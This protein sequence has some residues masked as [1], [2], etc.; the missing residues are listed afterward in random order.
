MGVSVRAEAGDWAQP[1]DGPRPV[2]A[3]RHDQHDEAALIDAAIAGDANAFA[4]LYDRHVARVYRHCYYRTGHRTDSEDLTQQTFLQAWLAIARY[5]RG[6]SPF[7]AWLLT[8]SQHLAMSHFR[9][10]RLTTTLEG[11]TP[12]TTTEEMDPE[13]ALSDLVTRDTVRTAILRLKPE[14]QQVIILRFIEGFTTEEI[15]A[16]IS[17]SEN[18]VRVLQHRALADLKRLLDTPMPDHYYDTEPNLMGRVR[19]ALTSAIGRIA[20]SSRSPS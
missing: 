8:I 4:M 10:A 2:A 5:R 1:D 12:T 17:K 20:P 3:S 7:I 16:A 15:A 9:K 19:G 13:A 18:N 11:D 14:R 6:P